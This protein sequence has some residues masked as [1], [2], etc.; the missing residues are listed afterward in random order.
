MIAADWQRSLL[1]TFYMVMHNISMMQPK[2]N[3][4]QGLMLGIMPEK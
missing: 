3:T 2:E 4:R 1:I